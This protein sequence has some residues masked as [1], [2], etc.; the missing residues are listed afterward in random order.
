MNSIQMYHDGNLHWV[1]SRITPDGIFIY[2]SCYSGKTSEEID[3]QLVLLYVHN[4]SKL[5]IY[6]TTM[7][8]QRGGADCGIFAAA[9][10][11]ALVSG[12]DSATISWRQSNMR[13]HL[14]KCIET[15]ALFPTIQNTSTRP[16][17]DIP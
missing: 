17:E 1:C 2:D 8:Q 10:C 12:A 11:L 14:K 6:V 7:Q 9:A 3:I 5:R 13:R 16:D 4:D 15:L